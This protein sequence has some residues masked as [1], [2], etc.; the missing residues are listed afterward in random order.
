MNRREFITLLGGAAT[1]P[2]AARGQSERVRTMGYLN[3]GRPVPQMYVPFVEALRQLGW[4]EGKNLIIDDR[5][6]DNDVER[7]H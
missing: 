4:I 2:L 6:S 3:P 1:W 7:L 5:Y